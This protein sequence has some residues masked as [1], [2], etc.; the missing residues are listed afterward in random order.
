[1]AGSHCIEEGG[2]LLEKGRKLQ[3]RD[4]EKSASVIERVRLRLR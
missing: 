1:M 3:E 2:D 4:A